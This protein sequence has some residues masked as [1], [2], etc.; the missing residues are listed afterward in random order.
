M[1][2]SRDAKGSPATH[3]ANAP[4]QIRARRDSAAG[5]E[6]DA[7][8]RVPHVQRRRSSAIGDGAGSVMTVQRP[9]RGSAMGD[10]H[11]VAHSR[12]HQERR[13]SAVGHVDSG[14]E[15]FGN[16]RRRRSAFGDDAVE[17]SPGSVA[18]GS[19]VGGGSAAPRAH[20][21]QQIVARNAHARARGQPRRSVVGG[22]GDQQEEDDDADELG[23]DP[24]ILSTVQGM[25]KRVSGFFS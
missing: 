20:L 12:V 23:G 10:G 22:L 1:S 3:S 24:G 4:Q 17:G 25:G 5:L 14:R 6:N 16:V 13:M 18:G 19:V 11:P 8:P 7:A 2:H 9:R 21:R 15:P